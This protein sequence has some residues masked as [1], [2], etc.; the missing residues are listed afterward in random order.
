MSALRLTS[1]L[2]VASRQVSAA[3]LARRGY[4]AAAEDKLKLSLVLPHQVG[5]ASRGS[6]AARKEGERGGR[7][8]C[9]REKALW[10]C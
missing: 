5:I 2:R 9:A 10:K 6:C 7:G 4:A 3:Q 8:E 1:S